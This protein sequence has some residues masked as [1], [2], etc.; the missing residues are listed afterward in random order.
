MVLLIDFDGHEERL[1]DAKAVIPNHLI[2]RVFIIGVWTEPEALR[3]ANLGSYETIGRRWRRIAAKKPIRLGGMISFDTM[4]VRLTVYV[5]A[6]VRSC[7][8]PFEGRR[9]VSAS[10]SDTPV[11][12]PVANPGLGPGS[13]HQ[14]PGAVFT[15]RKNRTVT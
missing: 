3:R 13:L 9:L 6:F 5:S 11:L 1:K 2:D 14:P 7:S 15:F 4:Q 10:L 12:H 8:S